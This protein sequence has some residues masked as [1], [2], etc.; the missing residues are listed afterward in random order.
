[1]DYGLSK[2]IHYGGDELIKGMDF[3]SKKILIKAVKDYYIK[4]N[5]SYIC[6]AIWLKQWKLWGYNWKGEQIERKG[7]R[8]Y[9]FSFSN[10]SWTCKKV[11]VFHYSC[12]HVLAVCSPYSLSIAPFVD[13]CFVVLVIW[14]FVSHNLSLCL[15]LL[16]GENTIVLT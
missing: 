15:T 9:T 13:Q 12:S 16:I 3:V 4:A 11:W 5:Q 1:M 8:R 10:R 2:L 14:G 7:E 6:R